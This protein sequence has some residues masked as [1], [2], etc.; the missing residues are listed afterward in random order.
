MKDSEIERL[1]MNARIKVIGGLETVRQEL[2]KLLG[3]R[4]TLEDIYELLDWADKVFAEAKTEIAK[5][6]RRENE[7]N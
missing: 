4:G 2:S 1:S 6:I 5:A 7:N 3:K